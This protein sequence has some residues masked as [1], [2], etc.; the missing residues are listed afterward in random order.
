MLG[1]SSGFLEFVQRAKLEVAI[2]A[3]AYRYALAAVA[4]SLVMTLIP[5]F[6]ATRATIVGHKQQAARLGALPLA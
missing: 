2:P 4:A 6:L 1:A 3:D 5:V